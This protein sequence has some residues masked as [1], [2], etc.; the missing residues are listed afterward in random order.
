MSINGTPKC[1]HLIRWILCILL[2][3][4]GGTTLAQPKTLLLGAQKYEGDLSRLTEFHAAIVEQ[5][6]QHAGYSVKF[7]YRPWMRV[8]NELEKGR[9]DVAFTG[10]YTTERAKKFAYSDAYLNS[11]VQ[12]F[13]KAN[14]IIGY[15]GN[16]ER[17]KSYTIGV[18]HGWANSPE[19]DA[20]DY[21]ELSVA[22]EPLQLITQLISGRIDLFVLDESVFQAIVSSKKLELR[23]AIVPIGRPLITH[24]NHVMVSKTLSDYQQ[25]VDAFN[26][27]LE[28]IQSNGT[29][30]QLEEEFGFFTN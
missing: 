7:A 10:Y 16:L 12:L 20:A 6:F 4:F 29:M 8:L 30:K 14:R 28:T 25:I 26:Q 27:G 11:H 1:L 5:S 24:S 15:D 2:I 13:R 22:Y 18:M 19:F 3:F 9:I 17:L 23:E 21:L